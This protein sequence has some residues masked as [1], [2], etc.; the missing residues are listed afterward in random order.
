MEKQADMA[1][2]DYLSAS[3]Y[4]P[5]APSKI[6]EQLLGEMDVQAKANKSG[7]V[8]P[9]AN[10]FFSSHPNARDRME[11]LRAAARRKA[12]S[13]DDGAERYRAAIARWWPR[14]IDDQVKLNDFATTEFLL[15]GLARGDW[16]ADLLYARGE[17]YRARGK[18]T[19]LTMAES[20]Y[21]QSLS[22][23][24][25]L[26]ESWR[27]LGMLLLRQGKSIEGRKMLRRYMEIAPNASDRPM[28]EAMAREPHK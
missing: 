8:A 5:M 17:L 4:D 28:I 25:L 27:S 9:E 11:Y 18:G 15:E 19:D 23:D 13:N 6:W 21:R 7:A 20:F 10:D 22:K 24:P 2:L 26:T 16:T 1:A 14:L 3:G 12:P